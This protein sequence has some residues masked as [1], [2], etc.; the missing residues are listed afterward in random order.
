MPIKAFLN[1]QS[2]ID[3][4]FLLPSFVIGFIIALPLHE[5]MHALCYPK[6]ATVWIGLCLRKL[7][8]YAISYH[9][10]TK[11]RFIIMSLAPSVLG[12]IPLV[13]F[14]VLLTYRWSDVWYI[15][16]YYSGGISPIDCWYRYWS[17]LCDSNIARYEKN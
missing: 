11:T 14:I 17:Y 10:L 7:A 1:K 4:L 13:L 3:P 2:P 8:A 15:L 16:R 12:I 6:S 5:F 9:P